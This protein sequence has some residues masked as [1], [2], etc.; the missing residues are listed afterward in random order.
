MSFDVEEDVEEVEEEL[1][2]DYFASVDLSTNRKSASKYIVDGGTLSVLGQQVAQAGEPLRPTAVYVVNHVK[3][4][5]LHART[6]QPLLWHIAD[7][8][9]NKIISLQCVG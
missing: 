6:I 1:S 7:R 8:S 4:S 2:P 9:R 5:S 3:H